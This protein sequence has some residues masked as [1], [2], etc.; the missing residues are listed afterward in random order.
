MSLVLLDITGDIATITLNRPD[1]LNA[2]DSAMAT[3]WRQAA[4]E[5]VNTTTVGAII[6]QANGPAFC[7][8][9]DVKA[10]ATMADR[11]EMISDLAGEI[12]VGL[13]ALTQS[14][15]P[16]VAAA[17]GTTAGGG[18]GFLLSSDY[19]IVGESS[20]V[21]SL[22]SGVGLTPD[23]SVSAN[24]ARAVGERRALA[25]TL[26]ET[27]LTAQQALEWGLVAEVVDDAEVT[28]RAQEVAAQWAKAP[29]AFGQA[30]RLIRA[31][32][33]TSYEEQLQDE[34]RTIGTASVTDVANAR[35]QAF[36]N[37]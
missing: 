29:Y 13:S 36:A 25:L 15:I 27:L 26:Q 12:N 32:T 16:V 30:K 1:A 23:L 4:V 2:V 5:A 9:G 10:M 11:S 31:G 33:R 8:G 6:V 35:I 28:A 14:A 7:A 19:A 20:K 17:H 37:R 18:L 21:G 22:Y 3:Q 24:L 34:A